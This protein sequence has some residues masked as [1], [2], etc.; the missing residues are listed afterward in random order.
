VICFFT[1]FF[2]YYVPLWAENRPFVNDLL[3]FCSLFSLFQFQFFVA[4]LALLTVRHSARLDSRASG[5]SW[6]VQRQESKHKG[7]ESVIDRFLKNSCCSTFAILVVLLMLL[8]LLFLFRFV[9]LSMLL[10]YILTNVE[11][12][13]FFLSIRRFQTSQYV[14][15]TRYGI[16][17]ISL[18]YILF[19]FF[20]L[21]LF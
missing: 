12:N 11:G 13:H 19:T 9:V 6:G 2:M 16:E 4:S 17:W 3:N 14:L 5:D 1:L 20:F 15:E 8:L 7:M 10:L 21:Y 18:F